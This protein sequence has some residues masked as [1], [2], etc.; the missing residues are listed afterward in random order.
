MACGTHLGSAMQP[1][2]RASPQETRA[3]CNRLSRLMG[4]FERLPSKPEPLT[5]GP[6][7]DSSNAQWL[8]RWLSSSPTSVN[9]PNPDFILLLPPLR[10]SPI[11]SFNIINILVQT[12]AG[13]LAKSQLRLQ[14]VW[15]LPDSVLSVSTVI[16]HVQLYFP[17]NPHY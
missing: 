8:F 12:F 13:I 1:E 3:I 4:P 7:L 2:P 9:E 15:D 6:D 5:K 10:T 17:S 11:W 16:Q 14:R